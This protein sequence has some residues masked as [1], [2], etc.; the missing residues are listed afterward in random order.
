M[1][2]RDA[3]SKQLEEWRVRAEQERLERE[4]ESDGSSSKLLEVSR[5]M[6]ETPI[7]DHNQHF[8]KFLEELPKWLMY[9]TYSRVCMSLGV[10]QVLRSTSFLTLGY[11]SKN[12]SL[13][14]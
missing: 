7:E 10:N 11:I 5:K 8:R 2:T 13:L 3:I 12:G 1:G 4:A 6:D 9:D 14:S